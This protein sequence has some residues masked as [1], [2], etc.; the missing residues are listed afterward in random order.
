MKI[1]ELLLNIEDTSTEDKKIEETTHI[2]DLSEVEKT[3]EVLEKLATPDRFIDQLAKLAV[4][5][6]YLEKNAG[7]WQAAKT[8]KNE[9]L[10]SFSDLSQ[11]EK[12]LRK[13]RRL[14]KAET[15]NLEAAKVE[16]RTEKLKK[17]TDQV[18]EK[19]N[20]GRQNFMTGL[21]TGAAGTGASA[22]A[23]QHLKEKEKSS[24]R[25]IDE[26]SYGY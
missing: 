17:L 14:N 20:P 19:E 7:I 22:L 11:A 1:G 18:K 24:P 16:K 12:N 10:G 13:I 8:K 9:I 5:K 4:L 15:I 26:E 21:F 25:L 23:Y 2:I 3:A 6:D